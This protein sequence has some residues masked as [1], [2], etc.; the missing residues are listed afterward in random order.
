MWTIISWFYTAFS[1]G[2]REFNK[3]YCLE[4]FLHL[5]QGFAGV[6]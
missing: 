2:F 1:L 3:A 6:L 5:K 4:T